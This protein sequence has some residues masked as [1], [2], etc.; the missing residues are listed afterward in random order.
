MWPVS[1]RPVE[2]SQ[3]LSLV[4]DLGLR[5]HT[6]R[7]SP[8]DHHL[9]T[10]FTLYLTPGKTLPRFGGNDGYREPASVS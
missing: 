1:H 5:R 10:V 9:P 4:S 7:L 3:G 2:C 6:Q 8:A